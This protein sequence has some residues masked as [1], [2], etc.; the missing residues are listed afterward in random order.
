[1]S[2]Q[3]Q[4]ETAIVS[5]TFCPRQRRRFVLWS[6]ILASS[7]GFI[8]GSVVAIA[9]P[10]IRNDLPATLSQALWISN[11]YM[12]FLSSLILIGGAAGDS[13]GLRRVFMRRNRPVLFSSSRIEGIRTGAST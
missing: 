11:S 7:M 13:Y 8:D 12:L 4:A 6:A 2:S 10:S 1:M 3:G 9:I 5:R